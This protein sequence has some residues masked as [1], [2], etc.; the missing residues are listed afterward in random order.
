MTIAS[1]YRRAVNSA[2]GVAVAVGAAVSM[3]PP[4]QAA[5][6]A[7]PMPPTCTARMVKVAFKM[8]G[9]AAGSLYG[10]IR[11]TNTS[12]AS[13]SIHG[14]GGLSYVGYGNGTQV[15]AAADRTPARV[16]TVVLRPGAR[17]H[18]RVRMVE[19]G[20][21]SRRRCGPTKVD[22]FRVYLPG[23]TRSLYAP[24]RT[25]GCSNPTVH[26]LSVKPYRR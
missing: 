19:A 22:G 5:A 8:G 4:V 21:Y 14:Y 10:R 17:A 2:L 24:H 26:L 15:G 20:N 9:G 7:A 12:Q 25:V 11:V 3:A 6:V 23:E 1:G 13:C 18:N 16:R